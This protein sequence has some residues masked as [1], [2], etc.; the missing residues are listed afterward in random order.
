MW[1]QIPSAF[2]VNPLIFKKKAL[3]VGVLITDT[4]MLSV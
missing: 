4:P 2:S 3:G 1:Q